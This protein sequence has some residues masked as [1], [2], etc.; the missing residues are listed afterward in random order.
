MVTA[1]KVRF[2]IRRRLTR[3]GG[4][5]WYKVRVDNRVVSTYCGD[6]PTEFD[7]AWNRKAE[8]WTHTKRGWEMRPCEGCLRVRDSAR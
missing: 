4:N 7:E 1:T 5:Q 3:K 6:A 2:H 8:P